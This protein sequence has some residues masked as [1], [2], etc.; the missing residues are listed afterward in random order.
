MRKA[1]FN[2]F[3]VLFLCV[4]MFMGLVGESVSVGFSYGLCLL[5]IGFLLLA[6]GLYK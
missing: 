6:I 4:F 5:G 3:I 2:L 1:L